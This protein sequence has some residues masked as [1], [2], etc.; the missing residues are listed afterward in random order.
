M[1]VG[2]S[3]PPEAVRDDNL[4]WQTQQKSGE[5]PPEVKAGPHQTDCRLCSASH[6]S[7][8]SRICSSVSCKKE[9]KEWGRGGEREK[10][11]FPSLIIFLTNNKGT[12]PQLQAVA[13]AERQLFCPLNI[14]NIDQVFTLWP[15][16]FVFLFFFLYVFQW[17]VQLNKSINCQKHR[18]DF[19][20]WPLVCSNQFFFFF[21]WTKYKSASSCV[22]AVL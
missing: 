4:C 3:V 18:I 5:V 11:N 2:E 9:D 19:L 17:R 10:R 14:I 8:Q 6:S 20:K 22:T 12:D 13:S 15:S 1:R 16:H 21:F 7:C